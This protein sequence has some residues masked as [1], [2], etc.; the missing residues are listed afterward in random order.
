MDI[1]YCNPD[2][3]D[4]VIIESIHSSDLFRV[5]ELTQVYRQV[6][7]FCNYEEYRFDGRPL[8]GIPSQIQYLKH[9]LSG[10]RRITTHPTERNGLYTV[11]AGIRN[12][13]RP[14]ANLHIE[15]KVTGVLAKSY[16]LGVPMSPFIYGADPVPEMQLS[17]RNDIHFMM[18][19]GNPPPTALAFYNKNT[20]VLREVANL[21]ERRKV[22]R[23]LAAVGSR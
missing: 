10:G 19:G 9:F 18:P 6:V 11:Y 3:G 14:V 12:S 4:F 16:D 23:D 1:R 17:M 15:G 5:S 7:R 13:L 21:E 8:S 22:I 2:N 20:G